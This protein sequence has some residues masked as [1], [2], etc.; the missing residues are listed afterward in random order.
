VRL[1]LAGDRQVRKLLF[2]RADLDR[3]IDEGKE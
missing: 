1:P 3:L 2:D